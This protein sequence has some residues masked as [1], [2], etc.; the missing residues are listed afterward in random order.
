MQFLRDGA[1]RAGLKMVGWAEWDP[2]AKDFRDLARRV[3]ASG[4]QAVIVD[5]SV[6][7]HVGA[8]V[9]DLRRVLGPDVPLV[10]TRNALPVAQLFDAV[11]PAARGV[12]VINGG[13][14][15]QLLG[16]DGRAFVRSFGASRPGGRVNE[17]DA[18]AAAATEVLLDAI[19]RSDGTR[20]SVGAALATTHLASSAIGPITLDRR[21]EPTIAT[22]SL[23]RVERRDVATYL[24]SIEG[25]TVLRA[26]TL[27][28]GDS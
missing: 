21:G 8:V 3:R 11:G 19:T 1:R 15:P 27:P 9:R 7:F 22:A 26:I 24:D 13:L 6:Y 5:G 25:A 16:P 12:Y 28:A 17:Y 23:M 2:E 4:A 14:E 18:Y 10:L 20:A